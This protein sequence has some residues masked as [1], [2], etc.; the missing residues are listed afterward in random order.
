MADHLRE[1][2]R[3]TQEELRT[4][5][6]SALHWERQARALEEQHQLRFNELAILTSLLERQEQKGE[7]LRQHS[8]WLAAVHSCLQNRPRWWRSLTGA[9]RRQW[10]RRQLKRAGLFDH[11]AYL[12]R[13]PD[14][15][16]AKMDPLDHYLLHGLHEGRSRSLND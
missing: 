9:R 14:V 5:A 11:D 2:L 15:A 3:R 13:Y 4:A 12:K 1:E 6:E 16:I 7:E 8:I 10:E